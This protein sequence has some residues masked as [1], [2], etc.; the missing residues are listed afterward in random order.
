VGIFWWVSP[1]RQRLE[2]FYVSS[3]RADVRLWLAWMK[4]CIA[5]AGLVLPALLGRRL[6]GGALGALP[7]TD[8]PARRQLLSA[9]MQQIWWQCADWYFTVLHI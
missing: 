8:T 1:K 4:G 7:A 6:R 2:A 9:T 5:G 3:P